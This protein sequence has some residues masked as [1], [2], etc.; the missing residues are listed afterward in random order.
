MP[1]IVP[2]MSE[3][4]SRSCSDSAPASAAWAR[5]ARNGTAMRRIGVRRCDI[6]AAVMR[7]KRSAPA[8][9]NHFGTENTATSRP[10][11]ASNAEAPR[12]VLERDVAGPEHTGPVV[13]LDPARALTDQVEQEEGRVGR[14]DHPRAPSHAVRHAA[15]R[16][17]R[18]RS[19]LAAAEPGRE[20]M[21]VRGLEGHREEVL[22]D[23]R[24]PVVRPARRR[25]RPGVEQNGHRAHAPVSFPGHYHKGGPDRIGP[26]PVVLNG[27]GQSRSRSRRPR[28]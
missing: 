13:L 3:S 20:G 8:P 12:G 5:P 17:H 2:N 16:A 9:R 19:D 11:R 10:S 1:S 26:A 14:G 18:D 4:P 25:D 7:A 24:R 15:D 27:A 28:P 23:A 21:V 22:G 6:A